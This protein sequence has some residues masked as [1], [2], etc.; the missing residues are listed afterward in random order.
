MCSARRLRAFTLIELLV[1]VAI[2]ALLISLVLPTLR[3]AREQAKQVKCV[4]NL[5]QIGLVM[6][7]YFG[8]YKDQFP[9]EKHPWPGGWPLSAFYYG[10]HPGRP[11]KNRVTPFDIQGF[12]YSF[13]EKPFN[14]YLFSGLLKRVETDEEIGTPEFE[15]RR[16]GSAG[17]DVF[18]CPSDIGG[19]TQSDTSFQTKH[20]HPIHWHTGA[21]YDINYHWVWLWAAGSS[22]G[23]RVPW[24]KRPLDTKYLKRANNFL[25]Q[26]RR[27][28]PGRF[29]MLYEDPFDSA[30][31]NRIPRFGWHRQWNRHSFLFLDG[32]AANV[33][34]DATEFYQGPGWKTSGGAWYNDEHSVDY[35]LRTLG[36]N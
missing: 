18:W 30:Q 10:G 27:R 32:H 9:F 22:L 12:R 3:N 1:V 15:E 13:A 16:K 11:R 17:W 33:Y 21:S 6:H 7:M 25:A 34:A 29:V 23:H 5:H 35:D 20:T 2:I 4:A 14:R 36:P 26:Q 31:Y 19:F 24:Y 8:E 28:D